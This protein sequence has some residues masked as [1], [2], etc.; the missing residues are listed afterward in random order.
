MVSR[1]E[2]LKADPLNVLVAPV[3]K[4]IAMSID[5]RTA[6]LECRH[7]V[8]ATATAQRK[9]CCDCAGYT[10]LKCL[11]PVTA[12]LESTIA[13]DRRTTQNPD[14]VTCP[15]CLRSRAYRRMIK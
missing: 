9:R 10:H 5:G 7:R 8:K 6:V 4:V 11:G 13:L 1:R 2:R 14:E 15:A 3:R 12:C